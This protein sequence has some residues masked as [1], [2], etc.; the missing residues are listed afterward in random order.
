MIT[1]TQASAS[2]NTTHAWR[3]AVHHR[4]LP[5]AFNQAC[6]RATT[7]LRPTLDRR[8]DPAVAIRP[9]RPRRANSSRHGW[10]S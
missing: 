8:G 5:N 9:T 2:Q 10:K 6:E 1:T 3:C 7:H 4:S